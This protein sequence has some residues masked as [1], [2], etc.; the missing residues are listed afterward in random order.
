MPDTLRPLTLG[1]LLDNTFDIYRRNFLLFVGISAVPNI[2][3]LVLQLGLTAFGIS[4]AQRTGDV[5]AALAGLSTAFASLFVGSIVTA[6]TTLAVSD[7][8]LDM[9]AGI[10]ASF[11]RVV[12]KVLKVVY[13]SF[14]VG[15]IVG[16]GTLL[17]IAPGIYWAGKYGIAV[18][19]VVLEDIPGGKALARSAHLTEGFVG[20]VIV[21]YFLTTIFTAVM[22][23]TLDTVVAAVGF[24]QFHQT[25]I[26]SREALREVATALG[27]ILFNPVT[28][29]ALT[30]VY[31][32]QRVRREAFDIE[33]LMR[34]LGASDKPASRA[35][36]A[37]QI[38][39][40]GSDSE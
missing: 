3:L 14:L 6:A 38:S 35:A 22:V 13:V 2:A 31:Y 4:G 27:G 23:T 33:Q 32:D 15:L 16:V 8:Y 20:R 5:V 18:P 24:I 17:C 37:E 40:G 12:G 11:S 19:A 25:G 7:L 21:V 29:I 30:L 10:M 34:M 36:A 1:K 39:A 26:L 28:A 9:P